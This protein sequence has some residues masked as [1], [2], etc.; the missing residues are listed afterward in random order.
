MKQPK[1]VVLSDNHYKLDSI[2]LADAAFRAAID[3]AHE[4]KVPVIDCGDITNDKAL[5][6]SEVVTAIINALKYALEK[7]VVV[8]AIVG[9]HSLINEKG[10]EHTLQFMEAYCTVISS[11]CTIAEFNFIPYQSK[12]E[13]F[14]SAINQF[15]KGQVV[16]GH[17]GTV[18]GQLGDYVADPSGID[19]DQVAPWTVFLGHLHSH[20]EHGTTIS[21]GSTR[22]QSFGEA[23]DGPKGFLIVNEDGSYTRE[24][25]NYRKHVII[26]CQYSPFSETI[27]RLGW[28]QKLPNPSDLVWVK[29]KAPSQILTKLKKEDLAVFVGHSNFK[30]DKISIDSKVI[31]IDQK[32]NLSGEE[33]LDQLIDSKPGQ[34]HLKKLWRELV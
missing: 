22:T 29:V 20:Y 10:K 21:I 11:P 33:I 17:Q 9:N 24:I 6:R 13:D 19:V 16:F 23:N 31:H 32:L 18:G 30:L 26:N 34:E 12:A 4:L 2:S 14:I 25:L 15:K 8:Y 7:G 27:K 3:K 1:C 28:D 5:L